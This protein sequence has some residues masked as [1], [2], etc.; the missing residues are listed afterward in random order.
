MD[1]IIILY[2]LYSISYNIL[3][4]RNYQRNYAHDLISFH[5]WHV[6][7]VLVAFTFSTVMLDSNALGCVHYDTLCLP[8]LY[9]YLLS[10]HWNLRS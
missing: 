8:H 6:L 2:I 10:T 7:R 3:Y 1:V 9:P 4:Q 5:A